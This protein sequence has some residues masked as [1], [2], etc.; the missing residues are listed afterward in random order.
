MKKIVFLISV[1]SMV[2]FLGDYPQVYAQ[3]NQ[4]E[5]IKEMIDEEENYVNLI[6][7][8]DNGC[9][10]IENDVFCMETEFKNF[11]LKESAICYKTLMLDCDDDSF[12]FLGLDFKNEVLK[13]V[14]NYEG[15]YY[16]SRINFT[17]I[18]CSMDLNVQFVYE[19]LLQS[20]TISYLSDFETYNNLEE[21]AYMALGCFGID[22]VVE[23]T[24]DLKSNYYSTESTDDLYTDFVFEYIISPSLL[25]TEGLNYGKT[26]DLNNTESY[27]YIVDTKYDDFLAGYLSKIK[28]WKVNHTTYPLKDDNETRPSNLV[29]DVGIEN[30]YD[31]LV[32][33]RNDDRE[34]S[35]ANSG[36]TFVPLKEMSF[37][38]NITQFA[39]ITKCG[40]LFEN[41]EIGSNSFLSEV[42]LLLGKFVPFYEVVLGLIESA[43]EL[44]DSFNQISFDA[45]TNK[46]NFINDD[47]SLRQV[48]F[49]LTN[50]DVGTG[51]FDD[52]FLH[53]LSFK[54]QMIIFGVPSNTIDAFIQF[55]V[56]PL[57]HPNSIVKYTC[58]SSVSSNCKCECD[59][60]YTNCY[61][62]VHL[63]TCSICNCSYYNSHTYSYEI[64]VVKGGHIASCGLCDYSVYEDHNL[65][66]ENNM[67][68]CT[69]CDYS[70]SL[71]LRYISNGDG[72]T[73]T[74][75]SDTGSRVEN[76][77]GIINETGNICCTKCGQ[78]LN[79]GSGGIIRPNKKEEIA[80]LL[81]KEEK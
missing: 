25:T 9:I 5:I 56:I 48:G 47:E 16:F 51:I 79:T 59:F 62:S 15:K 54:Q 49:K 37:N 65:R 69:K 18:S 41:E 81:K 7:N 10:F 36:S 44:S 17:E 4:S 29:L 23:E 67:E 30:E 12:E 31:L 70:I 27:L 26:S 42:N 24:T 45:M 22:E 32:V 46:F 11:Y 76:C 73:H 78:V 21:K 34:V 50:T 20:S 72:R 66:L 6:I 64:D 68:Y 14:V 8:E 57:Y 53:S 19:T 43:D 33:E 38:F 52:I 35:Y 39:Y 74:R 75:I 77:V 1:L 3:D 55:Q 58:K 13:Y 80:V 2:L 40:V 63:M 71:G 28:I 61:S 60:Q